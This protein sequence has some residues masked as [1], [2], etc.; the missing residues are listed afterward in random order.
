MGEKKGGRSVRRAREKKERDRA[1][2]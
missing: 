2:E 1:I